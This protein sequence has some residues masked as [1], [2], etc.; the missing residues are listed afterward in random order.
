[1]D[2]KKASCLSTALILTGLAITFLMAYFADDGVTE[3]NTLSVAVYIIALSLIITGITI[4]SVFCKC[5]H[6]GGSL[7]VRSSPGQF[8]RNCGKLLG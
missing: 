2:F 8:C 7:P 6:C 5:P 4:K 1:M 3:V